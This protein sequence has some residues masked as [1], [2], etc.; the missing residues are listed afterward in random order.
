MSQKNSP[1]PPMCNTLI[2]TW[3]W[4]VV[5]V[6]EFFAFM[7]YCGSDFLVSPKNISRIHFLLYVLQTRIIS[8]GNNCLRLLFELCQI[9]HH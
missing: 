5:N 7:G 8:V 3:L 6:E 9:I 1:H 4:L 2:T